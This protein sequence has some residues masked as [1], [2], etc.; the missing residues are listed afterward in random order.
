VKLA[1]ELTRIAPAGLNRCFFADNGS[2]AI[3]VAVKMSFHFWRNSG[4]SRKTRFIT[5]ANSY[6]GETLGALA[7]GDV[8]L[9]KSIYRPLLMD[10]ITVPSPDAFV[11]EPGV[12]PAEHA[13]RMFAHMD[14][15]LAQHHAEVAAVI[16]E[17]LVQC[18]GGMRMYDPVYLELL[19]RACDKYGVHL[20]A[21]E[22]AVGFGRTGTLF[23]CEQATSGL[24]TCACRRASRAVTCPVGGADHRCHLRR[25][26][27]RIRQAQCLPA[28]AQLH[29]QPAGM[30]RPRTRHCRSSATNLC[31]NATCTRR[32]TWRRAWITC[33]IT[34]MSPRSA[35][36]A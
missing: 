34:R 20:I 9:Y 4:K 1:E 2:A 31:W 8:D 33:A 32:L 24:T 19:R 15:A 6:H 16:V 30:R 3:E 17:P 27:R 28:F 11:R 21:D 29:R 12:S 13:E 18:A 25:F 26:L 5:L 35:G 10:V 23:A 14:K 22:I 7:V 36:A